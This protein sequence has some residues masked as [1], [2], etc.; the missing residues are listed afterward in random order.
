MKKIILCIIMVIIHIS[1]ASGSG[2]T[3]LGNKI[4]EELGGKVLVKD[5]DDL[6]FDF[7]KIKEKSK[8]SLEELKKN[9]K[10]EYQEFIYDFINEQ[11]KPII[12]VGLNTDLGSIN[13][14]GN[15]F[16]QPR[17]FYDV[18]ADYKFY[19]DLSVEKVV[20]QKF[21]RS[22][23]KLAR[24]KEMW[25]ERYWRDKNRVVSDLKELFDLL[26]WE[27][28]TDNWNKLYKK[29]KYQFMDKRDIYREVVKIIK[30][31]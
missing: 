24:R 16:K 26:E 18:R 17:A 29:H 5:L 21:Y 6:F 8:E 2:K 22:V 28:Q 30:K 31:L 3:T 9:W 20:E 10:K 27:K 12:F 14:H 4:K 11:M 7:V 23:D 1:G 19:I 13:I 25:M 15:V